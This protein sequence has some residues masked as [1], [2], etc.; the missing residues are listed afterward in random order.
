[1]LAMY[2]ILCEK[3][4]QDNNFPNLPFFIYLLLLLLLLLL[5]IF[6]FGVGSS[7]P[8]TATSNI[9]QSPAIVGTSASPGHAQQ[10]QQTVAAQQLVNVPNLTSI[11]PL[12]SLVYPLPMPTVLTA[13]GNINSSNSSSVPGG[14]STDAKKLAGEN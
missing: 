4:T 7:S 11:T 8:T 5:F 9:M 12:P 1:M 14:G 10:P 3:H 6:F 2:V 13:Q